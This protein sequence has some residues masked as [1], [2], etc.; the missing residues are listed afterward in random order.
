MRIDLLD[1]EGRHQAK[2]NVD[3]RNPPSAVSVPGPRQVL[4]E[5][6]L[7]WDQALDDRGRLRKCP[8]C[9]C[10][11]LYVRRMFPPLTGFIVVLVIGLLCF[12]LYGLE[13]VPTGPLL[14]MGGVIVLANI[15]FA[16]FSPRYLVCY[17]CSS[18]YQDVSISRDHREW[19]AAVAARHRRGTPEPSRE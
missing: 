2:L 7:D 17:G 5:R 9:G 6:F 18:R 11:E 8:A 12:A 19:D 14:A 4:Y 15:V 13:V 1:Y 16:F 3:P 10:T